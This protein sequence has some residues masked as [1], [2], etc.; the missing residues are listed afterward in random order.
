[1]PTELHIR[2][3]VFTLLVLL[4]FLFTLLFLRITYLT[5]TRS[6]ELTQRGIRQWTREGT[7][8]ARRGSILDT[9]GQTLVMSATAYIVSADPRKIS[10]ISLFT[11]T[12]CPILDFEL[13]EG[14]VY[15]NVFTCLQKKEK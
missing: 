11:Q 2:K 10:D 6:E 14:D 3:R 5:T 9:N 15:R 1:M 12:I 4:V 7:V 13:S 8:Y